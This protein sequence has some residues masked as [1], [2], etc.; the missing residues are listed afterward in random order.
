MAKRGRPRKR[1]VDARE[2]W[3]MGMYQAWLWKK[4]RLE[5]IE[6]AEAPART[7]D[8]VSA[9]TAEQPTA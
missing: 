3:L 4:E 5:E 6:E 8:G 7:A 1:R 2:A 9:P